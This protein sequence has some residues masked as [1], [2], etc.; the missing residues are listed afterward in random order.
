MY[1]IAY[2]RRKPNSI[3][4]IVKS[5]RLFLNIFIKIIIIN[6]QGSIFYGCTLPF[7]SAQS[8][9]DTVSLFGGHRGIYQEG[10]YAIFSPDGS[11]LT[12]Y[13]FPDDCIPLPDGRIAVPRQRRN[14]LIGFDEWYYPSRLFDRRGKLLG[15]GPINVFVLNSDWLWYAE[16]GGKKGLLHQDGRFVPIKHTIYQSWDTPTPDIFITH[17]VT[18]INEL[19]WM[20]DRPTPLKGWIDINT[21]QSVPPQFETVEWCGNRKLIAVRR[22]STFV[23]EGMALRAALP[24]RTTFDRNTNTR[25]YHQ[26]A[27]KGII[28]TM[29]R[30]LTPAIYTDFTRWDDN[31]IAKKGTQYGL[32]SRNGVVLLP[33]QYDSI[34]VEPVGG[35]AKACKDKKMGFITPQ[36]H[37]ASH[38]AVRSPQSIDYEYHS[39]KNIRHHQRWITYYA[40]GRKKQQ[41]NP[42][43]RHYVGGDRYIV[44]R[45]NWVGF[46]DDEQK[47][48]LLPCTYDSITSFYP[49]LHIW[50]NGKMGV[51]SLSGKIVLPPVF[52]KVTPWYSS[53]IYALRDGAYGLWDTSGQVILPPIYQ[54]FQQFGYDF[55]RVK[56][57]NRYGL[58]NNKKTWVLPI[59]YD[60]ITYEL[61]PKYGFR[62]KRGDSLSFWE[63][64]NDRLYQTGTV[65]SIAHYGK[66]E[67]ACY[68]LDFFGAYYGLLFKKDGKTGLLNET[69]YREILPARYDQL[70][71]VLRPDVFAVGRR[72]DTIELLLDHKGTVGARWLGDDLEHA[73]FNAQVILFKRNGK[74]CGFDL[75]DGQFYDWDTP[76]D[77]ALLKKP[78][79][80]RHSFLRWDA[81]REK[82]GNQ[83]WWKIKEHKNGYEGAYHPA[84]GR[85][86]P[87]GRQTVHRFSRDRFLWICDSMG[88]KLY[89]AMGRLLTTELYGHFAWFDT[90]AFPLSQEGGDRLYT[91]T[92]DTLK[93]MDTTWYDNIWW[94]E[95]GYVI[96]LK[97]GKRGLLTHQGKTLLPPVYRWIDPSP[98]GWMVKDSVGLLGFFSA[99]GKWI[100]PCRY[101]E[102]ES[103]FPYALLVEKNGLKGLYN[104]EGKQMLPPK[105]VSI[106]CIMGKPGAY[107]A[108]T[109]KGRTKVCCGNRGG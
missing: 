29:F 4:V 86:F 93:L 104:F 34:R 21:F 39:E 14:G 2:F 91:A 72:G 79:L 66:T 16:M 12:D 35:L 103:D 32:L 68:G 80:L 81:R 98:G 19:E 31:F 48:M 52:D 73:D 99:N 88:C 92:Q 61:S 7:A 74:P 65:P 89:N 67:V 76:F 71:V 49:Q 94:E 109:A 17:A 85:Y 100:L 84:S 97:N 62:C 87:L 51:A 106:E 5:R 40:K 69:T 107:L 70:K 37:W 78:Y 3:R 6:F 10:R 33:C 13:L 96:T 41:K 36:G 108:R 11:Q 28:D 60:E 63:W 50:K 18:D 105:Y 24:F 102:I 58:F 82:I 20:E 75:L 9:Q 77:T 95:E 8:R 1:H 23:Y 59:D 47:K 15:Q 101:N 90:D 56:Q 53:F 43:M 27:T 57:H 45:G 25:F 83:Y 38:L 42:E 64:K 30:P 55:I 54:Q 22:D 26:R 46:W 44:R